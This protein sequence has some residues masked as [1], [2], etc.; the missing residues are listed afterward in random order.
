MVT[1]DSGSLEQVIR[2]YI[3]VCY[4]NSHMHCAH[5]KGKTLQSHMHTLHLAAA[6]GTLMANLHA[7]SDPQ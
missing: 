4:N 7:G 5:C 2:A 6:L 1:R 3:F